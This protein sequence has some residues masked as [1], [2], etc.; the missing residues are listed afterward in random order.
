MYVNIRRAIGISWFGYRTVP[1]VAA[2]HDDEIGNTTIKFQFVTCLGNS[3]SQTY[4]L[5]NPN[6]SPFC[7]VCNVW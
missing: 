3:L 7:C 2:V 4:F 1:L 6:T 5:P